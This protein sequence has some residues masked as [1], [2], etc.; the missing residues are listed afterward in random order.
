MSLSECFIISVTGGHCEYR[1]QAAQLDRSLHDLWNYD[2]LPK[3]RKNS[4][5]ATSSATTNCHLTYTVNLYCFNVTQIRF[6]K[7][8]KWRRH[9]GRKKWGWGLSHE[10]SNYPL[11]FSR[12]SQQNAL[13]RV[14]KLHWLKDVR[15]SEVDHDPREEFPS[16]AVKVVANNTSTTS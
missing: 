11:Y 15:C 3:P 13:I 7:I 10:T 1:P 4:P 6:R 8:Q 16:T 12:S 9:R 5:T 2:L 14:L